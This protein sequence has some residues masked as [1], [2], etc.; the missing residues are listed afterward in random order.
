MRALGLLT[1]M[2]VNTGNFFIK[3]KQKNNNN[4]TVLLEGP[5]GGIY[6]RSQIRFK[7]TH[8]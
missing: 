3:N 4:N 2:F 5:N 8:V 6:E 7:D 1:Q